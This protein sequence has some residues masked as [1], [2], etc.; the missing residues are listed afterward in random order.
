MAGRHSY[1][2]LRK[3]MPSRQRSEVERRV[4][5]ELQQMLLG[6]L[7]KLMGLTQAELADAIGVS[8]ANVSQFENANDMQISTLQRIVEALGGELEIVVK[9]P[10]GKVSV[11]PQ[12]QGAA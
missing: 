10:T 11:T 8:Q 1:D 7:R 2:T 12:F 9:L 6:E 5:E 3:K 4:K